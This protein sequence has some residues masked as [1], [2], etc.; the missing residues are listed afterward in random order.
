MNKDV[1][2]K[3][4]AFESFG[5]RSMST[6][7]E[8][9]DLKILIDPG[10]AIAPERFSLPPT[11]AEFAELKKRRDLIQE[12]GKKADVIVISHYHYDH[13]TPFLD[14]IYCASSPGIAKELYKDKI[15]L[16]KHPTMN[17]NKSQ[18]QRSAN[19]LLNVKN[20]AKEV[21]F[22]DAKTFEFGD[23]KIE[24]SPPV[25]HGLE[26]SKLGYV[27]MTNIRYQD[28]SIIHASDIQGPIVEKTLD[29]IIE[30]NPNI[31]ILS[32]PP[33]Y[34]LWKFGKKRVELAEKNLEK[35]I[36]QCSIDK[37]I[38]D[39]HV[40]RDAK[41]MEKMPI[42]SLNEITTAAKFHNLENNLLEVKR[43]EI[44]EKENKS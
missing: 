16:T 19:F 2:L 8:T 41:Y 22:N 12:H 26:N 31:L 5:V 27:T 33:L 4:L 24:F 36:D 18:E 32:G 7:V 21:K 10:V 30:K 40:L 42:F 14:N 28:Y 29:W 44:F 38:L 9:P 37:I 25:P 34:L 6:F 43:K 13:Y 15:I 11:K 39:H 1:K 20:I 17:I 3:L 23:T 35:I